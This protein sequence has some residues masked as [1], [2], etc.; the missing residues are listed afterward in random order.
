MAKYGALIL[1]ALWLVGC[2]T[3]T[4]PEAR[5]FVACTSYVK[6]L[7][8]I[9]TFKPK[10]TTVQVRAIKNV[11]K[12]VR[13]ICN[14]AAEGETMDF[15]GVLVVVNNELRRLILIEQGVR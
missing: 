9:N 15:A 14:A 6:S 11:V 5:L 13:P 8:V 3:A 12:V 2:A 4:T 1:L 10:L 7:R